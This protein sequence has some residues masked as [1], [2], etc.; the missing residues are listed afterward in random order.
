VQLAVQN[1]REWRR[2]CEQVLE[3]PDL[4]DDPRYAVNAQR[5]RNRD[6]LTAEIEGGLA[7]L[8]AADVLTR[9]DAARIANGRLN[10]VAELIEHPQLAAGDRW[11]EVD[12]PVG[13]LRALRPPVRM[14]GVDPVMGPVPGVGDH[15]DKIL[16]ELGYAA[17]VVEAMRREG[18][19]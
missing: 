13:P 16:A 19:V 9:L 1:D 6:E 5:V 3:R 14:S 8:G 18:A 17:P 10:G 4:A 15:T 2:L 12:S 7:T 11:C